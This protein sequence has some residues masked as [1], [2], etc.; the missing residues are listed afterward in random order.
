VADFI[1]TTFL[2]N[3]DVRV[4][5]SPRPPAPDGGAPEETRDPAQESIFSVEE[6]ERRGRHVLLRV[7][8]GTPGN[9]DKAT[10]PAGPA[11]DKDIAGLPPT[12]S[13]MAALI[14]P[15]GA[16]DNLGILA[17]EA[18]RGACP[19][20]PIQRWHRQWSMD[21][22]LTLKDNTTA[23]WKLRLSPL[24]DDALLADYLSRAKPEEVV[25]TR[26]R[27][28]RD[29]LHTQ[30]QIKL[31]GSI[32]AE[33]KQ[34]K[35]KS[36]LKKWIKAGQS[37]RELDRRAAAKSVAAIIGKE[38]AEVGFTDVA[39]KVNDSDY[40]TRVLRPNAMS[41]VFTYTVGDMP[42]SQEEF[43]ARVRK[44]VSS[45]VYEG[46]PSFDWTNWPPPRG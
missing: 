45:V 40:G 11:Q 15:D 17:V 35:A 18:I 33:A 5:G 16:E 4:L 8:Y 23:W 25:L 28:G 1:A 3:K 31:T 19:H 12:R 36:E 2:A 27:E 21:A 39:M 32:N 26:Q 37:E 22:P 9:H 41:D 6:V 43:L 29:R 42:P 24:G 14:F 34:R 46:K 30:E 7:R 20:Q 10:S 38:I 44:A 13:Y